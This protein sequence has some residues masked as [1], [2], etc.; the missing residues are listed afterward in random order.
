MASFAGPGFCAKGRW[1]MSKKLTSATTSIAASKQPAPVRVRLRRLNCNEARPYP[2][3]GRDREWW[4]R[5][6]NARV[7]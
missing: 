4:Q 3:N 7:W 2:P 5:L 6:K 1:L